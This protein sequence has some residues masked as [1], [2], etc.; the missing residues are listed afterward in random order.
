[1]NMLIHRVRGEHEM[2]ELLSSNSHMP[3]Y[4]Y[5]IT[6]V[7]RILQIKELQSVFSIRSLNKVNNFAEL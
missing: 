2:I 1:M 6:D 3:I 4:S 7:I 5:K